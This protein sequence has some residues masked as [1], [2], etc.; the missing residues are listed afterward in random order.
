[1]TYTRGT[2]DVTAT[3]LKGSNSALRKRYIRVQQVLD[4]SLLYLWNDGRFQALELVLFI[5]VLP[6][7]KTGDDVCYFYSRLEGPEAHWIS[8]H[9]HA[10]PEQRL[11]SE[12]INELL[13]T[14]LPSGRAEPKTRA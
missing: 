14:L 13:E 4:A 8:Y 1:M 7:S 12:E 9:F 3:L 11:P 6:S 10:E 2:F 5:R